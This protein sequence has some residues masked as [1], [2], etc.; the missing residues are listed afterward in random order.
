[1]SEYKPITN[2]L[3]LKK[4]NMCEAIEGYF[5]GFNGEREPG[6]D[7]SKSF[8]HGWRNGRTDKG[9]SVVDSSQRELARQYMQVR[10][11]N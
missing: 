9:L 11:I 1:M 6:S 7:K 8:W 3:D 2:I 4:I 10:S 5:S